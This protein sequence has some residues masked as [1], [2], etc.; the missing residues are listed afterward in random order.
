MKRRAMRR[1]SR[2]TRDSI[3]ARKGWAEAIR[4]RD[5]HCQATGCVRRNIEAHHVRPKSRYPDLRLSL[6]NGLALCREHHAAWHASRDLWYRWWETR[7]PERA[8]AIEK[9]L[10]EKKVVDR[11][12]ERSYIESARTDGQEKGDSK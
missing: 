12:R 6:D 1:I 3:A 7:W 10:A 8:E 9:Y 5:V 11:K 4:A 2:R